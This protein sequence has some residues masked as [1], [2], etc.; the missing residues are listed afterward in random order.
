MALLK[1]SRKGIRKRP[2]AAQK[3]NSKKAGTALPARK[4]QPVQVSAD[5]VLHFF[6]EI[7]AIPHG[8]GHTKEISDYLAQFARERGLSCVQ[9]EYD[10]LI[11][12]KEASPGCE[13]ADPIALQGHIDMVLAKRPDK[14]M[15]M[16]TEAVTVVEDG[17]WIHADGTTLGA[18]NGIA[19]AMM[20]AALD[21]DSIRHPYLE[22]IFTSDEEIGLVGA[23][24][25]DLSGLKSRR[26]V[27]LDSETEG[28]F[29]AGC[30]GGGE[31]ICEMP[32]KKKYK[33]GRCACI[34][35][36]GLSGG[37]SGTDIHL[38]RANGNRLMARALYSLYKAY[39][40]R[41]VS[42]DGGDA[43]NAIPAH[44]FAKIQFSAHIDTE[45]VEDFFAENADELK[46]EFCFTDPGMTWSME[47]EPASKE[48]V[49][50]KKTTLRL[51]RFLMALP[52]GVTHVNSE[53]NGLPQ[54]SLNLGI[55]RTDEE[56]L[57]TVFMVRSGLNSQAAHIADR[58]VCIAEGFGARALVKPF[59][60]AWEYR[61]DSPLRDLCVST[62]KKTA[63]REP[64]VEVIH[65]GLECGIL[66]GKVPDLDCISIGPDLEN[67]HTVNERMSISSTQNVWNFIL[68]L[69]EEAAQEAE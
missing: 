18:D 34:S 35:L 6:R 19:V 43:D 51:L 22:C 8:S 55:V 25:I 49:I 20:M 58:L 24:H 37:H 5:K 61:A 28:V 57:Q 44:A 30:A 17:D 12:A 68:A 67:V 2:S 59:Y 40:F 38:G 4:A 41:L 33:G 66:S 11:I 16:L 69:L 13:K 62:Y 1:R 50:S 46:A 9:D 54:T 36:T 63:G 23:S 56:V 52:T 53:L 10:N 26:L 14:D 32:L 39:P 47:W 21:D 3:K 7:A 31:V 60:P 27:N 64:A 15:D 45:S 65:A 42:V 29:C 48:K